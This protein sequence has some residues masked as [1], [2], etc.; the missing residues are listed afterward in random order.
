MIRPNSY[1]SQKILKMTRRFC[2]LLCWH[3][4]RLGF[5]KKIVGGSSFVLRFKECCFGVTAAHVVSQYIESRK[6]SSSIVSQIGNSPIDI[7]GAIIDI[8]VELDIAT[9]RISE[10]QLKNGGLKPIDCRLNWPPPE[11]LIGQAISF[12][13]YPSILVDDCANGVLGDSMIGGIPIIQHFNDREII[14]AYDPIYAKIVGGK[15]LPEVGFNLSGCSG[16]PVLMHR[17]KDRE[18]FFYPIGMIVS[19]SNKQS[20]EVESTGD[21]AKFDTIRARR[22]HRLNADGTISNDTQ[23][24]W[25]PGGG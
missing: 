12:A 1:R 22:I 14:F 13:G 20:T 18:H 5:P 17:I 15:P 19:G 10:D 9:F 16:G 2:A 4:G 3:E 21:L 11:P 23:G 25:L 24:G 8:N 7:D 6:I